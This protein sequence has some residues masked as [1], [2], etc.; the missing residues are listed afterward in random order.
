MGR[1]VKTARIYP[2]MVVDAGN[3]CVKFAR[4]A[5]RAASPRVFAIVPAASLGAARVKTLR[6]KS[7]CRTA[8]ASCV[9]KSAARAL[10]SGCPGIIFID[11]S[12]ALNFAAGVDRLTVGADRLA[13]MAEAARRFGKSATVC[14]FGTAATFDVLDGRGRFAGGAIAPGVRALAAALAEAAARLP[15]ADLVAPRRWTGRNTRDAL[16][17]GVA[18]GYA[19][20]VLH[21]LRRLPS[22]HVVFT[23][24]DARLVAKLT[25][26][27]V[28]IDPLWTL[29]GIAAL[30]DIAARQTSK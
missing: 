21:L 17:S 3:T 14:D 8:V 11:K 18:G 13:N 28:V 30:G 2:M 1:C 22:K 19:G 23:G 15:V 25:G 12:T 26:L 10:R 7:G 9:T 24:G 27:E 16:R 5:R 29:R 20:L 6:K 4:I